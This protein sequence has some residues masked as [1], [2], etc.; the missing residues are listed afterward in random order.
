M[1]SRKQTAPRDR[2][3]TCTGTS[4]LKDGLLSHF[5]KVFSLFGKVFPNFPKI[6][7]GR[8]AGQ[9]S[10]QPARKRRLKR[11]FP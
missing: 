5:G 3:R 6:G 9:V 4:T 1:A 11:S 7:E 8:H 10:N 2:A